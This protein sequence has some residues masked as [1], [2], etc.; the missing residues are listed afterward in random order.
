MKK[1]LLALLLY[2]ITSSAQASCNCACVNGE[3]VPICTYQ[4]E[5]IYCSY[6]QCY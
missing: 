3:V 4:Y 2:F 5:E 1:L 6:K